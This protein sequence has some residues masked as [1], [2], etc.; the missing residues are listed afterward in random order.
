M[1]CFTRRDLFFG[2]F[3]QDAV[4]TTELGQQLTDLK[5]FEDAIKK[6]E[7]VQTTVKKL[8]R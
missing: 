7:N 3:V 8:A 6:Y 1:S 5:K 4:I 2:E